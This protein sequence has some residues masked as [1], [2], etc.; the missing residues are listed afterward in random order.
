MIN[1]ENKNI[2]ITGR[3]FVGN[4]LN[5]FLKINSKNKITILNKNDFK[6]ELILKKK[7]KNIDIIFH[8]ASS[9][10]KNKIV[11]RENQNISKKLISSI[12]K[13][14]LKLFVHFGSTHENKSN[15]YGVS[16][17]ISFNIIKDFLKINKISLHKYT[18]PN[19]YGCY[20]KPYHNSFVSTLIY[21]IVKNGNL[22]KIKNIDADK[23]LELI[24]VNDLIKIIFK[25]INKFNSN[26]YT[27]KNF[28]IRIK[29]YKITIGKIIEKIKKLVDK[30]NKNIFS[31]SDIFEKNLLNI[32]LSYKFLLGTCVNKPIINKDNRG[33][34][35]EL[36]KF[37][38]NC[39]FF[40]SNS[41]KD[42]I[43]GDHFH[44]NKYEIFHI[45][46]GKVQIITKNLYNDDRKN[47]SLT[48]KNNKFLIIPPFIHHIFKSKDRDTV[49]L[50]FSSE[51]FDINNPDTFKNV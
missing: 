50:F 7:L 32:I 21:E 25:N 46:K 41:H 19:I 2:L 15:Y 36:Y 27:Y 40:V 48:E 11:I 6:S 12:D 34:L 17:K 28:F 3:G 31:Y 37:K 30:K 49:G 26:K 20:Y 8:N 38:G 10:K 39:Q 33:T 18:I 4:Y 14:S 47:F 23:D 13:N 24:F 35:Y 9:V 22:K 29:G 42:V 44:T 51:I 43:R 16:K 45:I 1:L 5:I